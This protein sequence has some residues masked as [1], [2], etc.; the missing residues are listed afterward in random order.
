MMK[1]KRDKINRRNFFKTIGVLG[2]GSAIASAKA[3]DEVNEPNAVQKAEMAKVS[4][5]PQRKLG[6]TGIKLPVLANGLMFDIVENQAI[7]RA[8]LHHDIIYWDTAHNYAGGN[9]ELGIGEFLKKNPDVRKDLFIVTKASRARTPEQVER[10]LKQSLERMNTSYIDLYFGI[11]ACDNPEFQLTDGM[12]K[13]AESAKKRKLIKYFGFSTHKNMEKCLMAASKLDWIDAIMTVYNVS[14]MQRPEMQEAIQACHEAGIGL[15]AMKV[16]IRMQ[17]GKPEAEEKVVTH[18]IEKGYTRE[19]ALIKAVLQDKRIAVNCIRMENVTL[20]KSNIAAVLD[21]TELARKDLGALKTYAAETCSGYCAGC[22]DICDSALPDVPYV[23]DIMRY[24]MYYN[25]YGD[26]D[27][28]RELFAQVPGNV[29]KK[30]LAVDYSAAEA[31]CP[32]HLPIGELVSE[33]V[34]KLA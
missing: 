19:Q 5:L 28:A 26:T 12:R 8:N 24:L 30:L 33:A 29:R 23:S 4:K 3:Q 20:L 6:K 31:R 11:H 27:R 34:R 17:R 9:S 7:L 22:A 25:S 13:W 2:A 1:E 15:I 14:V 10:R 18:F 21:K 16:L 32:Q